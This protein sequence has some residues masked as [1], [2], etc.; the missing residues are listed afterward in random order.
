MFSLR[1][2]ESGKI[3]YNGDSNDS[4]KEIGEVIAES[5]EPIDLES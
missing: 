3:A 5:M 4:G 2:N 1:Q